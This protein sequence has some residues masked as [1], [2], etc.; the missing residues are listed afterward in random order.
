MYVAVAAPGDGAWVPMPNAFDAAAP[1]L[2]YKTSLHPDPQ[3]SYARVAIVAIDA[4]RVQLH[5]VA[6]TFEPISP[7]R[8]PRTGLIPQTD[9]PVLVAAFNGG[10]RAINGYFGMMVSGQTILPP[11]PNSD[12]IALYRDGSI[13]IAPWTMLESTLPQMDSFRQTPP[14]LAYQGQIN[15]S[16]LNEQSTLWGATLDRHT[17]IWRSALG[18]ST[19]GRTL[20][21]GAGESLT[22]RRLAEAMLAAGASD[23]AELDVNLSFERFLSYDAPNKDFAGAPLLTTM[24]TKARMYTLT[25]AKRDF[26]YLTLAPIST[27]P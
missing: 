6:G 27:A 18:I 1:P 7:L 3:R 24:T 2:M 20:F 21:Y 9:L 8:V 12:T 16:L 17:V 26:F 19:D 4:T 11:Q 25:P 5:A 14:Y 13:R 22:A 15:P 23:V 10:F